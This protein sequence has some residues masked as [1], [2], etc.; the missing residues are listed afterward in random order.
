MT[1]LLI[2]LQEVADG[3]D[4]EQADLLLF[5]KHIVFGHDKAGREW[6]GLT[7]RLMNPFA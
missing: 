1:C 6:V 4:V 2:V 7:L 5:G 3:A